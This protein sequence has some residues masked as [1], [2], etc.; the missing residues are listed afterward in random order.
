MTTG[1]NRRLFM[2]MILSMAFLALNVC[3]EILD[4]IMGIG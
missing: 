1:D 3:G 4:E 2:R